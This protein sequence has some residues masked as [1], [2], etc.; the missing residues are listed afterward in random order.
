MLP[1]VG[2]KG[3]AE[4]LNRTVGGSF[5]GRAWQIGVSNRSPAAI[6]RDALG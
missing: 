2:S 6:V 5:K 1:S 3:T 4:Q